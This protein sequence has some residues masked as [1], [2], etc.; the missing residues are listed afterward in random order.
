MNVASLLQLPPLTPAPSSK[1]DLPGVNPHTN[2]MD[3]STNIVP[4]IQL[5]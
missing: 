2:L 1:L 4:T 5:L 3:T